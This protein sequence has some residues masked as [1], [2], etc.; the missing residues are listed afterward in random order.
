[1]HH[2]LKL[3]AAITAALGL[4]VFTSCK[5]TSTSS[6]MGEILITGG[7]G[8][9][10]EE[11]PDYLA[12]IKIQSK[13]SS[14][15]SW[16]SGVQLAPHFIIT[17]ATCLY[18][19]LTPREAHKQKNHL[20]ASIQYVSHISRGSRREPVKIRS[21]A[22]S[23]ISSVDI[24]PG[25]MMDIIDKSIKL[26]DLALIST[27][28][29]SSASFIELA[30]TPLHDIHEV[31]VYGFG[32]SIHDNNLSSSTHNRFRRTLA[33]KN[34]D[35]FAKILN[36]L[37]SPKLV[38]TLGQLAA[39]EK[40]QAH[41]QLT[42]SIADLNQVFGD[43]ETSTFMVTTK[44]KGITIEKPGICPED[45]GGA[46]VIKT[47]GRDQLV[48]ITGSYQSNL[49]HSSTTGIYIDSN[50]LAR[51]MEPFFCYPHSQVLFLPPY[52]KW[53]ESTM[54]RRSYHRNR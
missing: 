24:Y 45:Q 1:M 54:A 39:S 33:T 35:Y 53:I 15:T 12:F 23:E 46:V 21:I 3:M 36:K 51:A 2:S 42:Q 40:R 27:S 44:R 28:T 50:I 31:V 47:S 5:Q 34:D 43:P 13:T 14:T 4:C 52:H 32:K 48:G 29:K 10:L 20:I 30:S 7:Q 8:F 37:N 41:E 6:H 11:Y 22:S 19:D 38:S 26:H 18:P 49:D 25:Y 16:C 9:S 17:T